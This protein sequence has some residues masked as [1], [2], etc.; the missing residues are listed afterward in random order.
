M[1]L[2][3]E[4]KDALV[5]AFHVGFVVDFIKDTYIVSFDGSRKNLFT[6]RVTPHADLR[7]I[8]EIEPEKYAA[9]L[10]GK[11]DQSSPEKRN[12]FCKL[13]ETIGTKRIQIRV[14]ES[15]ITPAEFRQ[16]NSTW[17]KFSLRYSKAPYFDPEKSTANAAVCETVVNL[18]ALMLSLIEYT[19]QGIEGYEEGREQVVRVTKHE[20]NPINRRLCLAVKGYTCA[21]CG[22]EFEKVYGEIGKGFIEVHHSV[23][24][25]M[26][27]DGHVVD[28]IAE[29]YPLCSNCHSMV[30]RKNPPYTIEELK[31]RIKV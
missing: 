28:P 26:M 7:L 13:W 17:S 12:S 30:H 22:L 3:K 20:R 9:A 18:C 11:I 6:M 29:L 21:V 23:P 19:I 4:L 27:E 24:V 31:S 2:T 14:N 5:N 8:V 16:K 15:P 1:L 25:S 10:M